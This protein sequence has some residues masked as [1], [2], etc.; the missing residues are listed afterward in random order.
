MEKVFA[1]FEMDK[2]SY[3]QILNNFEYFNLK[4]SFKLVSKGNK[5]KNKTVCFIGHTHTS[6]YEF[7]DVLFSV[8]RPV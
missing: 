7:H 1:R 8:N 3:V 4:F 5:N 2:S 6:S